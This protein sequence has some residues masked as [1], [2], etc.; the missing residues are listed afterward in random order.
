MPGT[1]KL[2]VNRKTQSL[3]HRPLKVTF[4]GTGTSQGVP[5]IACNCQVCTSTDSR[6][7]RL[8]SSILLE[9]DGLNIVVDTTPDFRYQ[10]LRAEVK[11]LDAILITHAHKDHIAGLDD[12][13]AFNYFQKKSIDVYAT[14]ATQL[15]IRREF[16]YVF[17]E[18]R[19][20]GIP[21]I[22]LREIDFTPIRI[23]E[24]QIRPVKV[25]HYHL[26][27]C[28]FRIG[29]F[30][31]ITDANF[32]APEEKEKIKGSRILVVNALRNE[33]HVSHFT[34]PQAI[35][36]ADEL[37]VEEAYFTHI[38]HQL[39]LHEQVSKG[40]P[41]GRFLAYDGLALTFDGGIS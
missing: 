5:M 21:E 17:A 39:G 24:L 26:P 11:H 12:V 15:E 7:K 16:P 19:Y 30:T 2:P 18:K 9:H 36:L 41:E 27:V 35:A 31:Y 29:E 38:S 6:D 8:R 23:G 28:G 1:G 34:L 25:M 13:R 3:K 32:I 20:P 10:M 22:N 37:G 33:P 40:L 14:P 4:L